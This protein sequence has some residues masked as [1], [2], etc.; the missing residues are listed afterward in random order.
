MNISPSL[1]PLHR[2][3][4]QNSNTNQNQF[5][6]FQENLEEVLRKKIN[7]QENNKEYDEAK[8]CD[9]SIK[10]IIVDELWNEVEDFEQLS[11][12]IFYGMEKI[13]EGVKKFNFKI[14]N[15]SLYNDFLW[16]NRSI[17]K[18]HLLL[19]DALA[20]KQDIKNLSLWAANIAT[21]KNSFY[22][23]LPLNINE[24]LKN[25]WMISL[26]MNTH[27]EEKSSVGHFI[28]DFPFG[29]ILEASNH[30]G[31]LYKK[32]PT[33]TDELINKI[34]NVIKNNRNIEIDVLFLDQ[35]E[36]RTE[37]IE[38][39]AKILSDKKIGTLSLACNPGIR[40]EGARILCQ[41]IKNSGVRYLDL[42]NC[43]IDF[44]SAKI[45]IENL[46]NSINFIDLSYNIPIKQLRDFISSTL[47]KKGI[48]HSIEG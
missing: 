7:T 9:Q 20:N 31:I 42:S 40:G 26:G 23:R 44:Y 5:K 8:L 47:N 3:F 41:Y 45:L 1:L 4:E 37:H 48:K 12:E 35:N 39:L 24:A 22:C 11:K 18:S 28:K 29:E 14:Q 15:I 6:A 46:P 17:P 32:L 21:N 13:I 33:T 30:G 10:S 27:P 36:I 43:S 2:I 34:I 16:E 19:L 38:E 25:D